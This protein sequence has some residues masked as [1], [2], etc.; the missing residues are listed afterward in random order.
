MYVSLG[1]ISSEEKSCAAVSQEIRGRG[2]T[3]TVYDTAIP[4]SIAC[5]VVVGR[6]EG[7]GDCTVRSTGT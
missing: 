4:G 6:L 7:R 3:I 5:S 1:H 2:D